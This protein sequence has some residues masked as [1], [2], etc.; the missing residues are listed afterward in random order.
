MPKTLSEMFRKNISDQICTI[1]I[2]WKLNGLYLPSV[3]NG[4]YGVQLVLGPN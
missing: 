3:T 1:S 2:I 4:F